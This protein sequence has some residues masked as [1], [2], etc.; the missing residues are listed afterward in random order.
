MSPTVK[1]A[2]VTE[3]STSI[4]KAV[5]L[6]LLKRGYSVAVAGLMDRP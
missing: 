1:V 3:A 4:G 6:T 2:I 5:A